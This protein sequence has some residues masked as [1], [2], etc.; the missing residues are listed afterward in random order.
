AVNGPRMAIP[1]GFVYKNGPIY[2]LSQREHGPQEQTVPGVGTAKEFVVI[3]RRKGRDTS[4]EEF[5]AAPRLL[6]GAQWEDAAKALA[7]KGKSRARGPDESVKRWR[8][9]CDILELT[10]NVPAAV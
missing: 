4:L 7:D 9:S 3:T 1:A 6:Q 8:G 5:S 10:P 2:V